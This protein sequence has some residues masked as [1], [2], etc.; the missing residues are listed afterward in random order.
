MQA[1][2]LL[3]ALRSSRPSSASTAPSRLR[4]PRTRHRPL[5]VGLAQEPVAD[6]DV[7]QVFAGHVAR[8]VDDLSLP[9]PQALALGYG[10]VEV[11]RLA[12]DVGLAQQLG[13]SPR[14]RVGT[15]AP[16]SGARTSLGVGRRARRARVPRPRRGTARAGFQAGP[17]R[18]REFGRGGKAVLRACVSA[19]ER[20]GRRPS[21]SGPAG[22]ATG[23]PMGDLVTASPSRL[24]VEGPAPGQQLV[25]HAADAEEVAAAVH[26]LAQHLLGRHVARRYR[27]RAGWSPPW[28]Q[29]RDPE[30]HDLRDPSSARKTLAGLMSRWTMP[31]L[32]AWPRPSR[33]CSTIEILAARDSV[34]PPAGSGAGP[35]RAAAPSRCTASHRCGSRGRRRSPRWGGSGGRPRGPRVRSAAS[36]RGRWRSGGASPSGRRRVRAEDRGLIDGAHRALSQRVTISYLPIRAIG[37]APGCPRRWCRSSA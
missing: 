1:H 20:I 34:G 13:D 11:A 23:F 30:V 7:A 2:R 25:Q 17:K 3:D 14:P 4:S 26:A 12:A 36:A 6:Q 33:T 37:G 32:W 8:A 5:K 9:D 35:S 27:A 22:S 29:K 16:A 28:V 24:A 18:G 10:E 19:R 21:N 31:I 15:P